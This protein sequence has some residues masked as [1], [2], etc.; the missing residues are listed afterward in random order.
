MDYDRER[1]LKGIDIFLDSKDLS[2]IIHKIVDDYRVST[3]DLV[4]MNY[5][6]GF[7]PYRLIQL[8]LELRSRP[9]PMKRYQ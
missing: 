8:I 5:K 3:A 7:N 2:K 1:I 6:A 9:I 4:A